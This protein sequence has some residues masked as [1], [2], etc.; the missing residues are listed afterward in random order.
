MVMTS[1]ERHEML[2]TIADS[3]RDI[4]DSEEPLIEAI[5]KLAEQIHDLAVIMQQ[6]NPREP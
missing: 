5:R 1:N 4:R 2:R 6:I 3:A